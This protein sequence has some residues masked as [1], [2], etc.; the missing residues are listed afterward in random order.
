MPVPRGAE[1]SSEVAAGLEVSVAA[2]GDAEGSV[3]EPGGADES[4]EMAGGLE[5]SAAA[6]GDVDG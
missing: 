2:E 4:S 6:E 5:V 1:E 3:E